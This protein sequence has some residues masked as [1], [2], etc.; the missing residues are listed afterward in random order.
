MNNQN[1][2]ATLKDSQNRTDVPDNVSRETNTKNS[3]YEKQKQKK[4]ELDVVRRKGSISDD[5]PFDNNNPTYRE[6]YRSFRVNNL[7]ISESC[8]NALYLRCYDN[9][10]SSGVPVKNKYKNIYA[11]PSAWFK[12]THHMWKHNKWS[13]AVKLLEIIPATSRLVA[14]IGSGFKSIRNRFKK[15]I[16]N[17]RPLGRAISTLVTTTAVI[18]TLAIFGVWMNQFADNMK[19]TPAFK[20]YINGEYAGDI[21]SLSEAE[22]AKMTVEQ[23]VSRNCKTAYSF[24]QEITYEPTKIDKGTNLSKNSVIHAFQQAAHSEMKEGYGLYL[25]DTLLVVAE[26][27]TWLTDSI[28]EITHIYVSEF[29]AINEKTTGGNVGSNLRIV[30]GL[31]ME[32]QFSTHDEIRS[33]FSL[34]TT[35]EDKAT[36]LTMDAMPENIATVDKTPVTLPG[37]STGTA[38]DIGANNDTEEHLHIIPLKQTKTTLQTFEE[39]IPF[40]E[41]V[42]FDDTLPETKRII[43]KRGKK[44]IR[45]A[46]YNVVT[47]G[48]NEISREL[49]SE[50]VIAEP[51]TQIVTQG[52]RPLTEYEEKTR[53]T[54]TYI[55][56]STGSITS[57]YGW[58]SWGSYNEFHKGTDFDDD[59]GTKIVAADGGEVIQARNKG[60]GYGLCIL[61]EHDDGTITRY[62]HCSVMHVSEGD[63][64]AQGE[65]I[66][67]IGAT[68][69]VTGSH[70]HF[71]V[72]KDNQ[73]V[74]P[75]NYLPL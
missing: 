7:S 30:P 41:T 12:N 51:S 56:P 49:I 2:D 3:I 47:D 23:T 35:Q 17:G 59:N 75:G 65:H 45:V 69:W 74:N 57:R 71:E 36:V 24:E 52:T 60:D 19:K 67:E 20:L 27:E 42:K 21:L 58:R 73:T 16:G 14:K 43:T 5:D 11:H 48:E 15:A 13:L 33:M 44:G 72:I 32:E 28:D 31:Y 6:L 29:V 4:A 66:G 62:A 61:I 1:N 53:S 64:V 9:Y 18:G 25:Y 68:G 26:D 70:L 50:K 40:D 37:G 54:G 39:Y 34:N 10:Y 38:T 46:I 22:N 63:R 8:Y 55:L